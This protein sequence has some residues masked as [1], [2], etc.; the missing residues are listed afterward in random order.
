MVT[1]P[2]DLHARCVACDA[3][4]QPWPGYVDDRDFGAVDGPGDN[5]LVGRRQAL[6]ASEMLSCRGGQT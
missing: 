3:L 5:A 6:R 2:R 1:T 4:P